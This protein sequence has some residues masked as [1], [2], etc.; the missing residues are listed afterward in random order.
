MLSPHCP[1]FPGAH[2]PCE[3]EPQVQGEHPGSLPS[4]TLAPGA[5]P[6]GQESAASPRS[7]YEST[8]KPWIHSYPA[9]HSPGEPL[10]ELPVELLV[11]LPV[12]LPV[13]LLVELPI[14][15]P[16]PRSSPPT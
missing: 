7:T 14:D 16:A 13:E 9:A 8:E 6:A 4:V 1:T 15:P 11:E 5:H 12:E 2:E 10:E 3:G